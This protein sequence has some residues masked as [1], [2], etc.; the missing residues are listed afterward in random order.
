MIGFRLRGV[1][2]TLALCLLLQCPKAL[3]SL[4]KAETSPASQAETEAVVYLPI[5]IAGRGQGGPWAD[6]SQISWGTMLVSSAAGVQTTPSSVLIY[7]ND[8]LGVKGMAGTGAPSS[9]VRDEW[10]GRLPGWTRLF[11]RGTYVQLE[12]VHQAATVFEM[13]DMYECLAYGPESAHSAGEEA[14]D[15]QT[16]VP[17]AE[18]LADAAGKCLIYGPAVRDYELMAEMEALPDPSA[19]VQEIAPHV[20]VWMI[21]LAKYQLWTDA[22]RDE[23]GNPYTLADFTAWI[24]AW[25]SWIKG[26]NPEARVWTQL[27][28]GKWDAMAK[29]C[30]PPQPPEYILEYR[31]ALASAGVDGVWVIPSQPCMPCPPDPP[32]EFLCST[33]PRDNEY[34]SRSLAVFQQAI[35]MACV[36]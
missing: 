16:W 17:K 10:F 35:D 14:L 32:P 22:G 34:Y 31:E 33:D 20:D 23:A 28:I 36:P 9:Q 21:Q 27:G 24:T 7:A 26:A 6:C 4:P 25:V 3:W 12:T 15:P 29:V 8:Q 13:E 30:L 2:W 18:A 1:S 5:V 11:M 19:I